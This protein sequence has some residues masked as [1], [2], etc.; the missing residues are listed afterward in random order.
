MKIL[1]PLLLFI[2][3]LVQAQP[4]QVRLMLTK[5]IDELKAKS[6]NRE[7]VDWS[8]LSSEAFN[9]AKD[10][11]GPEDLGNSI[12]YLFRSLNDYHGF[13][14]YKDSLF[15]WSKEQTEVPEIYSTEFAKKGNRFFTRQLGD[16]AYLRIPHVPAG[17]AQE[18]VFQ[19]R[20]SLCKVL[21]KNPKGLVFDLRL[22]GGGHAMAMI[23][24]ISGILNYG[25]VGPEDEIKPDGYFR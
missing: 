12:R 4:K 22:N 8:V 14:R 23:M 24:G 19:L 18:R 25:P 13:F 10:A 20:D 6:M 7:E 15:R 3:M 16:I 2:P 11:E 1:I 5:S 9:L 17:V 21:S